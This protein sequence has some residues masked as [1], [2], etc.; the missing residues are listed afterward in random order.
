MLLYQ[1]LVF[2]LIKRVLANTAVL[3]GLCDLGYSQET[4]SGMNEE[5]AHSVLPRGILLTWK[6]P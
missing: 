5:K 6:T 2:F 4:F 3:T 1:E